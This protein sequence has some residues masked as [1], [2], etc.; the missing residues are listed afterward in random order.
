VHAQTVVYVVRVSI[1]LRHVLRY[2]IQSVFLAVQ[3]KTCLYVSFSSLKVIKLMLCFCRYL[4]LTTG[5][6]NLYNLLKW[7]LF[8]IIGRHINMCH[9][10]SRLCVPRRI[11]NHTM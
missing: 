11:H 2:K 5:S 9:V 1:E 7:H 8:N 6:D 4:Q 10:P 3:V